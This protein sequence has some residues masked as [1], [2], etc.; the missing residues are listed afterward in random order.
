[1]TNTAAT[2][3]ESSTGANTNTAATTSESSTGANTNTAATT[4]ESSTSATTASE[5]ST[6][7]NS[8]LA[9]NAAATTVASLVG[10]V[11]FQTET[12][13]AAAPNSS[14][15]PAAAP[16]GGT[17]GP[18]QP[19][20]NSSHQNLSGDSAEQQPQSDEKDGLLS[21]PSI[22]DVFKQGLSTFSRV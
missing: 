9:L 16:T 7:V 5:S 14:G 19:L 8:A 2:T 15:A 11:S 21:F 17:T 6:S 18:G 22:L 4:S 20:L 12:T 13:E 3:S 1:N 10:L